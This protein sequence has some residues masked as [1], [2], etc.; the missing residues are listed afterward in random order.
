MVKLYIN[1]LERITSIYQP[2][3]MTG[4]IFP[5]LFNGG[6]GRRGKASVPSVSFN[7]VAVVERD[8][9]GAPATLHRGGEGVAPERRRRTDAGPGR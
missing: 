6:R 1:H 9:R 7:G 2:K 4:E 3:N 8:H 5:S